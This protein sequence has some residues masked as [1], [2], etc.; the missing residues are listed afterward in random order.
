MQDVSLSA[1]PPVQTMPAS[2]I[3]P[4]PAPSP[5][6]AVAA[7]PVQNP[8]VADSPQV[9][10]PQDGGATLDGNDPT[11]SVP[12]PTFAAGLMRFGKTL[13]QEASQAAEIAA[14]RAK[15]A[16]EQASVLSEEYKVKERLDQLRK[17]AGEAADFAATRAKEAAVVASEEA[18]KAAAAAELMLGLEHELPGI[19]EARGAILLPGQEGG[20]QVWEGEWEEHLRDFNRTWGAGAI[21]LVGPQQVG[22]L[23]PVPDAASGEI[24]PD[25]GITAGPVKIE[26]VLSTFDA[27]ACGDDKLRKLEQTLR[28][29]LAGAQ[30]SP[31]SDQELSDLTRRVVYYLTV[32]PG[33]SLVLDHAVSPPS[34]LQPRF[35]VLI[36][37]NQVRVATYAF[38][39]GPVKGDRPDRKYSPYALRLLSENQWRDSPGDVNGDAAAAAPVP[40]PDVPTGD[41][42]GQTNAPPSGPAALPPA[43]DAPVDDAGGQAGGASSVAQV[44]YAVRFTRLT[45]IDAVVAEDHAALAAAVRS[46]DWSEVLAEPVVASLQVGQ[47]L[48]TQLKNVNDGTAMLRSSVTS[49]SF[50][51][52]LGAAL[53]GAVDG[54]SSYAK[55]LKGP[56][57]GEAERSVVAFLVAE[58][59]L[60]DE[61]VAKGI[62]A[63]MTEH[64]APRAKWEAT[65]REM[66]PETLQ[67]LLASV[68]QQQEEAAEQAAL[69]PV[70]LSQ[71]ET[72][73]TASS[74]DAEV[75][76]PQVGAAMEPAAVATPTVEHVGDGLVHG[77]RQMAA[78]VSDGAAELVAETKKGGAIATGGQSGTGSEA[79]PVPSAAA[80]K[81]YLK[82]FG[83]GLSK[84]GSKA[85]AGA[86]AMA[87]TVADGVSATPAA[88]AKNAEDPNS[89][90]AKIAAGAS[91]LGAWA[92][93]KGEA[94]FSDENPQQ[95]QQ[96]PLVAAAPP[97]PV[98]PGAPPA[99]A[100]APVDYSSYYSSEA[101]N[102]VAEVAP[103]QA[104]AETPAPAAPP[105]AATALGAPV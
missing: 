42:L 105:A 46:G 60:C 32:T 11:T 20:A 37:N 96:Q 98:G 74:A 90:T 66:P 55:D 29:V 99:A 38:C 23:P 87:G 100:P 73:T 56:S 88:V 8:T 77:W 63:A 81:G 5:P 71:D 65:L 78:A 22:D 93:S 15:A 28:Q 103:T 26:S 6:P 21:L 9:M 40:A 94:L 12:A 85:A 102:I 52:G 67:E 30:M 80:A 75:A 17:D 86:T 49:S 47:L 35:V 61:T 58:A 39:G 53:G 7:E 10:L 2:A 3:V 50:A 84:F 44:E 89:N 92:L 83:K 51:T 34:L 62:C 101:A 82:G 104:V 48:E 16:A 97:P 14:E 69:E 79:T 33:M 91:G 31:S 25:T 13:R 41:I 36:G 57:Y 1:E 18:K 70:A 43:I 68:K 59:Q 76:A 4:A 72:V 27:E 24:S 64:G 19:L 45:E 54:V 95:S